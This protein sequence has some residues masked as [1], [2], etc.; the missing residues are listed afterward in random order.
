[1]NSPLIARKLESLAHCLRIIEDKKPVRLS[2]LEN[3][4]DLQDIISVNLERSI[5]LC[6]DI[7]AIIISERDLKTSNTMAGSFKIL[8]EAG[9]LPDDL[10]VKLQK[11][12]GFRNVS[13]HEY[14]SIDWEIVFDIIHHHLINF[15]NF[16]ACV[17]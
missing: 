13:V 16:I 6:V 9:I 14:D 4:Y 2:D 11:A 8:E 3:N 15:R 10:S 5:Q 7:S 12:V 17:T 1:M